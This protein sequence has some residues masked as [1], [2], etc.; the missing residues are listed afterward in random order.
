MLVW[1]IVS[2]L[3]TGFFGWAAVMQLNDPDPE[4]WFA[5]Y[6]GAALVALCSALA[7]PLPR[8]AALLAVIALAWGAAIVPELIGHWR[9]SDLGASMSAARPEVEYGRE[10]G[11]LLILAVYCVLSALLAS[12]LRARTAPHMHREV[13]PSG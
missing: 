10:L 11:G 8:A 1:R 7:R 2:A 12:R 9:P 6:G 3:M 4:R 5:L 13:S